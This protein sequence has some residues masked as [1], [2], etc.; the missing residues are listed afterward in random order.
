MNVSKAFEPAQLT[1]PLRVLLGKSKK[2]KWSCSTCENATLVTTVLIEL[3]VQ[4]QW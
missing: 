1:T 3:Q 2:V 4:V